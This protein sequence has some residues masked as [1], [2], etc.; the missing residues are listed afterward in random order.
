VKKYI[1]LYINGRVSVFY[2]S[3]NKR[4]LVKDA[5]VTRGLGVVPIM[6]YT[7]RL[8]PKRLQFLGSDVGRTLQK[9]VD[10]SHS[11]S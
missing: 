3:K 4:R 7:W 8:C 10:H 6:D 11:G 2:A 1:P 9:L 5:F